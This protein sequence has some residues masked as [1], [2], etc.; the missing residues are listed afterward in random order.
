MT[1]CTRLSDDGLAALQLVPK[2]TSLTLAFCSNFTSEGLAHISSLSQLEELDCNGL[3][4]VW[5]HFAAEQDLLPHLKLQ[6]GTL[7]QFNLSGALIHE[8]ER[9]VQ[10]S[11]LTSLNLRGCPFLNEGVSPYLPL[12]KLTSLRALDLSH[13]SARTLSNKALLELSIAL[14]NL[15]QLVLEKQCSLESDGFANI[16]CL[17]HL[18]L[19]NIMG[20]RG[21]NTSE[22]VAHLRHC[23]NLKTLMI[24]PKPKLHTLRPNTPPSSD[25]NNLLTASRIEDESS[26]KAVDD[27]KE[28]KAAFVQDICIVTKK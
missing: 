14:T 6:R 17:Q 16:S 12:K 5:K 21:L 24:T 22:V 13:M 3:F 27:F 15:Q 2:L 20:I 19:I 1:G 26:T 7:K 8:M 23:T 10:F 11:N 28:I 18:E 9:I 25:G 4:Q